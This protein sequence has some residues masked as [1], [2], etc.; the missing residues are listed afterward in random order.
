MDATLTWDS[1]IEDID[2]AIME[3]RVASASNNKPGLATILDRGSIALRC[4]YI[5]ERGQEPNYLEEAVGLGRK[6]INALT[7]GDENKGVIHSHLCSMLLIWADVINDFEIYD[8]VIEEAHAHG[9]KATMLLEPNKEAYW[10]T[11]SLICQARY[12]QAQRDGNIAT[13]DGAIISQRE[14]IQLGHLADTSLAICYARLGGMLLHRHFQTGSVSEINEAIELMYKGVELVDG[15]D[16]KVT[17]IW[18][19][20][21]NLALALNIHYRVTGAYRSLEASIELTTIVIE[22]Y[23]PGRTPNDTPRQYARALREKGISLDAVCQRFRGTE[24]DKAMIAIDDAI[25]CGEEAMQ[26]IHPQDTEYFFVVSGLASWYGT[27]MSM[28]GQIHWGDKTLK[29]LNDFLH[30][31]SKSLDHSELYSNMSHVLACQFQLLN[32]V[33][34]E[35][36]LEKLIEAIRW[37]REAVKIT[38]PSEHLLGE[39]RLNL[40]KVLLSKWQFL[41]RWEQPDEFQEMKELVTLTAKSPNASLVVRIQGAIQGGLSNI[42]DGRCHEAYELVQ[43]AIG[44]LSTNNLMAVSTDDL[45]VLMRSVSGLGSLASSIALQNGKSNFEALQALEA[46]RC[47]ISELTMRAN[48]D[49]SD[50]RSVRPDLADNYTRTSSE[51]TQTMNRMQKTEQ[52]MISSAAS[53][54]FQNLRKRQEELLRSLQEQEDEIRSL[55]GLEHFQ[56]RLGE[57]EMRNLA[58][59][60]PIIVIN[61]SQIQSDAFIVAEHGIQHVSLPNFTYLDLK[62]KLEV[63]DRHSNVARSATRNATPRVRKQQEAP[64]TRGTISDAL[65]WLWDTAVCPVLER[66]QLTK[67]KRVWWI[68]CGLAGRAPLHAAGDHSQGCLANTISRVKSSYISS[69]KAFH[70]AQVQQKGSPPKHMS[71]ATS[72]QVQRNMLLVT[73]PHSPPYPDLDTSPEEKTIRSLFDITSRPDDSVVFTH[74]HQPSPK[75]VLSELPNHAFVHFACHGESSNRDPSQSALILTETDPN[76]HRIPAR[77]TVASIEKVLAENPL[78]VARGAGTLAYL[79]ACSTAEQKEG[80]LADEAIHLANSLQ[81]LGFR[82]IIGT[83]W[84]ANDRAAGEI[85]RRFYERLMEAEETEQ[86]E[87]GAPTIAGEDKSIDVAEAFHRAITEYKAATSADEQERLLWCPFIHIGL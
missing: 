13:L 17:D 26:Q 81:T 42:E 43:G 47:V 27:K 1:S 36:A 5:L 63:F 56:Q 40:A 72:R 48:I 28:T 6:A 64:N 39:R 7:H 71:T 87:D 22:S 70:H 31:N 34:R 38:R 21:N 33:D 23:N 15:Y 18:T 30:S 45:K 69:F 35:A 32:K 9:L 52:P 79:S 8:K 68:T 77:L 75:E 74:L 19:K 62:E 54:S 12:M 49:L 73:V 84:G 44:L 24:P 86:G 85:A 20:R 55:E 57:L 10:V 60:G 58:I 11:K 53:I 50:L 82:N 61:V 37:G 76:G 51:L 3:A 4:K 16:D 67:T 66:T 78:G 29:L 80:G 83:M 25:K 46:A 59:D 41:D 14:L 65:K 2:S